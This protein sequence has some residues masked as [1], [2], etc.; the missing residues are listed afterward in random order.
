MEKG[1]FL[2]NY[3][4]FDVIYKEYL[5]TGTIIFIIVF[6]INFAFMLY[7]QKVY[8]LYRIEN[9]EIKN[10]SLILSGK[11]VPYLN[12][13]ENDNDE[14]ANMNSKK[15]SIINKIIKEL[16]IKDTDINFTFKLSKYYKKWKNLKF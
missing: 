5:F 13:D 9:P 16:D 12:K 3:E 15:E 10:Y 2:D 7:L 6:L 8:K 14:N 1:D 4:N 11:S